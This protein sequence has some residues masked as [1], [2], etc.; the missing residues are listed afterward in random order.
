MDLFVVRHGEAG[1]RI[2]AAASD[3]GRGLT[4]S[5]RKEVEVLAWLLKDMGIKFDFIISSSLK[6]AVETAHIISGNA[7]RQPEPVQWK[8]LNP[9]SDP[10]IFI[11]R[12]AGVGINRRIALVGHNPFLQKLIGMLVAEGGECRIEL[13]K[14]GVA[15]LDVV[16]LVPSPRAELKWL[17]TPKIEKY[18]S[19][20][21]D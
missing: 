12:L 16:T 7:G 10:A 5:G 19:S 17:L 11:R 18:A 4:A 3:S 1:K 20:A 9:E 21:N 14:C 6:R 13:K 2:S 8:E 15:R